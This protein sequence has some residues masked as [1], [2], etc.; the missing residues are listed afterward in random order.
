MTQI[1]FNTVPFHTSS[2]HQIIRLITN[3]NRPAQLQSPKM[4]D[5]TWHLVQSCWESVPSK[6]PKMSKIVEALT[7]PA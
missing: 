3:G 4:E 6:R 1:F 7:L 5:N 2:E